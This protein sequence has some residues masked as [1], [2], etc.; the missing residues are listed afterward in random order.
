M[1][2]RKTITK[3]AIVAATPLSL[4]FGHITE[5]YGKE[6]LRFAVSADYPPFEYYED[7]KLQGF[8]I[9]LAQLLAQELDKEAVFEDMQ[10]N[11]IF[12]SLEN[13]SVDAAIST[14]SLTEQREKA[15]DFST[16]YHHM[17]AVAIVHREEDP[18]TSENLME[19]KVACQ[20]GTTVEIWV[21]DNVPQ[22]HVTSM[23]NTNM[24]I[25]SLKA[26][27]VDAAAVDP[28]Q[29]AAFCTKNPT[30]RFFI[31]KKENEKSGYVI[32]FPKGSPWRDKVNAALEKLKANGSLQKLK[33]KWFG[34][35]V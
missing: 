3:I 25:E 33:E 20:M 21:H 11:T 10:F 24:V 30:L 16:A 22:D 1:N 26:K 34:H 32:A 35:E 18:L 17:D 15:F 9:E 23:D 2:I 6:P 7:G 8:D 12:P 5:S 31:V 13:G 19:K 4:L 28:A 14:I 27:H 29:G